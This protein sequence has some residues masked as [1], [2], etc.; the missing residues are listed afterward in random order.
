MIWIKKSNKEWNVYTVELSAKKFHL[1]VNTVDNGRLQY[2]KKK[3][4]AP[5]D[6]QTAKLVV[7]LEKTTR[8]SE[9]RKVYLL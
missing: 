7:L 5:V 9:L 1:Q 8:T 6:N 3:K 2:K 4:K